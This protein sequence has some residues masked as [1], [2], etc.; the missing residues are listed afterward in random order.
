MGTFLNEPK[1]YNKLPRVTQGSTHQY[2][3][4]GKAM[5]RQNMEGKR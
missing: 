1:C 4:V 3:K 2:E 5:V